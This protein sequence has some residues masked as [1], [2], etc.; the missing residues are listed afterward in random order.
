MPVS[1]RHILQHGP[2]FA[3]FGEAIVS[4]VGQRL[5]LQ[6][7]SPPLHAPGPEF[8]AVVPP[9]PADLIDDYIRTVGGSR[10][11]YRGLIPPHMFSQWS[12]P[13]SAKTLKGMPYPYPM[14]RALNGGCRVEINAPLPRN[15]ELT[16]SARLDSL[17]DDGQRAILRQKIVTGTL[18][19]PDALVAYMTI[20]VPLGGNGEAS[21]KARSKKRVPRYARELALW[22]IDASAGRDYALLTGDFNPIHWLPQAARAAGFGNSILHGFGTM[23]RAIEGLNR[24]LWAGDTSRLKTFDCRFTRP[25][26]LPARV[27]LY[28][29][30][31]GGVFVGDAPGG[32]AYLMGTFEETS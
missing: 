20:I 11:R 4:A 3:A 5:G 12:Y 26:V 10:V 6:S 16:V 8:T 7:E 23:A 14:S 31:T 25:L 22:E 18:D 9:R 24:V 17:D 19:F 15:V 21:D 27:G 28:T 29:D 13:L 32:P 2:T 30:D 1:P